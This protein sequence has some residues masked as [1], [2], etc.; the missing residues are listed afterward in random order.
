LPSAFASQQ[1]Q[2]SIH[3]FGIS[4][5]TPT[6]TSLRIESN[7]ASILYSLWS[8]CLRRR[9]HYM[10]CWNTRYTKRTTIP[11]EVSS[12]RYDN[13]HAKGRNNPLVHRDV[14]GCLPRRMFKQRVQKSRC[15]PWK[16]RN[17]M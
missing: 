1:P 6:P 12:V 10:A 7:T 14:R 11:D 8:R 17:H 13:R 16:S 15:S 4:A 9:K 5:T 3:L 2:S